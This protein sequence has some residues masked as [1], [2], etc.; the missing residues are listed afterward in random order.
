MRKFYLSDGT[1][2]KGLNN[3]NGI[4][5]ESPSGLGYSVKNTYANLGSGF[6]PRTMK[7]EIQGS[8]TGNL[9]F[10][11][12]NPYAA[13][14]TFMN[15]INAAPE[16]ILIYCPQGSTEYRRHCEVAAITKGELTQ[17]GML[18]V[19]VTFYCLEPWY[20]VEHLT[21][22][23]ISVTGRGQL[24]SAFT[25]TL[26]G[27]S[28]AASVAL[29]DIG[30]VTFLTAL[31]TSDTVNISTVPSDSHIYRN[32]ADDIANIDIT[33]DPFFTLPAGQTAALTATDGSMVVDV[34]HYWRTV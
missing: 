15:W 27:A 4:F 17:P 2:T 34:Y 18:E 3:E 14:S 6:F 8:I 23:S 31:S 33:A 9:V 21:G 12:S 19:T 25:I 13:Y 24:P 5:L 29:G 10:T 30:A 11:G 26:S 28:T 16:L 1:Q 32:G 20:T 7:S 22:S